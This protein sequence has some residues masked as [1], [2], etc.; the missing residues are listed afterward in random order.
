MIETAAFGAL[1]TRA[2][3]G[4]RRAV[5]K[6]LS[7]VERGG[8]V[9]A[10][11]DAVTHAR[12]SNAHVIGFTGAPGGG[13]STLVGALVARLAANEHRV[14][15]LAIDPSSPVTGGAIL[16]DRIRMDDRVPVGDNVFIRSMATRGQRGGLA[17][18][19]PGAL[20]CLDAAGF[21]MI[22]L[23]TAGVGQVEI[24]V[25]ANA[26]TTVVVL[27]PGWGDAVQANKS[28]VMEIADVFVVNKADRPGVDDAVRDIEYMLDLGHKG[29]DSWRPPVVRTI[30]IDTTDASGVGEL[31][32]AIASHRVHL[33]TSGELATRR[34][35]RLLMEVRSVARHALDDALD[36]DIDAQH[37]ALNRML[38]GSMTPAAAAAAIV[39]DLLGR[40]GLPTE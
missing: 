27:S 25:V 28:G 16:G 20:R 31:E 1:L 40:R 32:S 29:V 4:E 6:L 7:I 33:A 26:D 9:A 39:A 5:G 14:G 34:A 3:T 2:A 13:K 10:A 12:A 35:R 15:V 11:L 36:A 18:A 22:V 24:D 37:L 30:A 38:A 23:E 19:V 21:D 17:L 8:A